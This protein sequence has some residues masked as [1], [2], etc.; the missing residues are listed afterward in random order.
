MSKELIIIHYFGSLIFLA[1]F[2][3]PVSRGYSGKQNLLQMAIFIATAMT[4]YF[5]WL[6][7]LLFGLLLAA[8]YTGS[9]LG[10]CKIGILSDEM[11]EIKKSLDEK[12]VFC[13]SCRKSFYISKKIELPEHKTYDGKRCSSSGLKKIG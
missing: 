8:A 3:I 1:I 6:D 7:N 10:I 13:A 4:V 12:V 2:L 9:I 5:G 11:K